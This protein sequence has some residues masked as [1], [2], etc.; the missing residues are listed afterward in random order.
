MERVSGGPEVTR[1]AAEAG[2]GKSQQSWHAMSALS[3]STG[4]TL[5]LCG[6]ARQMF[7]FNG[8]DDLWTLTLPHGGDTAIRCRAGIYLRVRAVVTRAAKAFSPETLAQ[9]AC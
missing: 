2:T 6:N 8:T 5:P 1:P 9:P 4:A 7:R 3:A